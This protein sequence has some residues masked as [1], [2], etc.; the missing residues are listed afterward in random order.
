MQ[1][2][3]GHLALHTEGG[4]FTGPGPREDAVPAQAVLKA[5]SHRCLVCARSAGTLTLQG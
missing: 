1:R 2:P 3:A 5:R 4:T